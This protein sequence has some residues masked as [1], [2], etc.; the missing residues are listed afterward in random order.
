MTH[1]CRIASKFVECVGLV[2]VF[3]TASS[4]KFQATRSAFGRIIAKRTSLT[5][6]SE[7]S[8][9]T[10][11]E[12]LASEGYTSAPNT[13]RKTTRDYGGGIDIALI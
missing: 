10:G 3:A 4:A 9:I 7:I 12:K 11:Q 1:H 8:S 2:V 6:I 13:V 5:R